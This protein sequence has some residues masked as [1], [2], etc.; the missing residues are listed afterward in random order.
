MNLDYP[1]YSYNLDTPIFPTGSVAKGEGGKVL[2]VTNK[3]YLDTPI[4]SYNRLFQKL[5]PNTIRCYTTELNNI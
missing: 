2:D 5:P 3:G 1:I 4:Y